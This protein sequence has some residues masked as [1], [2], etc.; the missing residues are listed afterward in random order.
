VR[1]RVANAALQVLV[2]PFG[3]S[4]E[5][6]GLADPARIAGPH[7]DP[8]GREIQRNHVLS[9]AAVY[10]DAAQVGRSWDSSG[11]DHVFVNR[12]TR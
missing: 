11:L 3:S 8:T 4:L 2:S 6:D 12:P 7:L 5:D 1:G 10:L 9:T